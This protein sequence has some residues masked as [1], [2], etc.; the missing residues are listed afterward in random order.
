MKTTDSKRL[1]QEDSKF[2]FTKKIAQ[3]KRYWYVYVVVSAIFIGLGLLYLHI[4]SPLYEINASVILNDNDD[5]SKGSLGGGLGALMASFSM[6]GSSYKFVEDEMRRIRS[7]ASMVK[8]VKQLHLNESYYSKAGLFSRKRF[9]YG[10]SPIVVNVPENVLDTISVSTVFNIDASPKGFQITVKQNNNKVAE[11]E[12]KTLPVDIKTP[13]GSFSVNV[14]SG[15]KAGTDLHLVGKLSNPNIVAE[16]LRKKVKVASPSKKSSIVDLVYE[17]VL[18]NRGKDILAA[19]IENYNNESLNDTRAQAAASLSFVEER[20]LK[21]Y[22]DL[23]SSEKQIESYKRSNKIVDAEAEAE[24]IFKKKQVVESGRMEYETKA[25]VIKMLIDFL[26]SDANRYTLIPFAEGMPE[27]AVSE[28]NKLVLERIKLGE[29]AKGSNSTL[30]YVTAQVDAMR[31]NMLNSLEKQLDAAKIA[32]ADLNKDN[33]SSE[34]RMA[35]IPTIER[36]LLSL[37]REQKIKNQIYAFL[38]QKREESELK[39]SRSLIAGKYVDEAYESVEPV[40]PKKTLVLGCFM[41]VG[42]LLAYVCVE[43]I[44]KVRA[45]HSVRYSSEA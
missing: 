30:R 9:Y 10:D 4:K 31:L 22:S 11:I 39:L 13:Y 35:G 44:C 27:E 25:A 6:G 7:H 23:E 33:V 15:Y 29:N 5:D 19:L 36:D 16:A 28:Y 42:L 41:L 24:Y 20:L 21:L 37:Y 3:T 38:L 17:D 40:S 34:S 26:Q 32:L 1:D 45:M 2:D 14:A 18:V 8:V 12:T 43:V